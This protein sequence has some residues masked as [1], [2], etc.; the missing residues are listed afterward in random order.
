MKK[1]FKSTIPTVLALCMMF[2]SIPAFA[3]NTAS[4]VSEVTFANK[5]MAP[6]AHQY[7]ALADLNVR[8]TPSNSG[9]IVGWLTKGD[10][11]W[12]DPTDIGANGWTKIYGYNSKGT[13]V[14][15]YVGSQYIENIS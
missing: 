10:I 11:V 6:R 4:P 1:I 3:V 14:N 7:K 13:Y 9:Q 5:N 8:A 15:G 2:S 12:Y